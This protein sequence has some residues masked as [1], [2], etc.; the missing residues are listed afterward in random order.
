MSAVMCLV[1]AW[2]FAWNTHA[3]TPQD[4]INAAYAAMGGDKIKTI[5]LTAHLEQ[6]DPGESYSVS[7]PTKPDRGASDLIRI[8][9]VVRGLTR[10][11]WVRPKV[12]GSKRTF[13]EIVTPTAGFVIGDD[14]VEAACRSARSKARS[15][16]TPCRAD[17]SPQPC[18]NLNGRSS[19]WR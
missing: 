8:R 16:S 2:A 14:A 10:N 3:A 9:D 6:F 13:I 12:D 19:L 11:E 7:D 17:G 5:S 15:P 1:L 4:R 18:V